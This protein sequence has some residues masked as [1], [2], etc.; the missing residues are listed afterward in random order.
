MCFSSEER[1]TD[2]K[3]KMN[4]EENGN[5]DFVS[6]TENDNSTNT[7]ETTGNDSGESAHNRDTREDK[8]NH[9][10]EDAAGHIAAKRKGSL[11][12]SLTG[13]TKDSSKVSAAI[14]IAG[15]VGPVHE[16]SPGCEH[17]AFGKSL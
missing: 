3:E 11:E 12:V 10:P 14:S 15:D 9:I 4:L 6:Y 2:D 7:I 5:S 8:R 17:P 16:E 1:H 13:P